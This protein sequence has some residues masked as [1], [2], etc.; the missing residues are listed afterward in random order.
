MD[1]YVPSETPDPHY[2]AMYGG[3]G[4]GKSTFVND[5]AGREMMPVG[6]DLRSCTQQ[7][8]ASDIFEVDGQSI[9]L[10]D[11][12]GFDDTT[13]SDADTLKRIAEFLESMYR[14]GIKL[15]GLV[16]IHRITDMRMMGAGARTYRLLRKL[17]G[18]ETLANVTIVTNMWSDPPT[19]EEILRE[20]QLKTDFFKGALDNGAR[21]MRRTEPGVQS[22]HDV[23]RSLLAKEPKTL[24]IQV[25]LVD[26]GLKLQDTEAGREVE[27]KLRLQLDKQDKELR[28]LRAEIA[29]AI[30]ESDN[31][32]QRELQQYRERKEKDVELVRKQLLSL[33][34]EI[35]EGKRFWE[36]QFDDIR[37]K[38]TQAMRLAEEQAN[39]GMFSAAGRDY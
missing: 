16:Y 29:H 19:E 13:I 2:I 30:R 11:T 5:A 20:H 4:V 8:M 9:V 10:L 38:R 15:K 33:G 22:A 37:I 1:R 31:R 21:M 24:D 27:V 12:P 25:E 7:V 36:R 6:H 3:T 35:E 18:T 28:D 23:L 14:R 17:C 26:R 39:M 34:M 32:A